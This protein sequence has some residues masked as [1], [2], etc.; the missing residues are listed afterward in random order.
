MNARIAPPAPIDVNPDA[1]TRSARTVVA[2]EATAVE[3]LESRIGPEFVEA[4]RLILG[5]KGRVVV[6]GM[7]SP[8]TSGARS[9]P[10]WPP[11]ARRR[12]SCTRAK[13]ATATSA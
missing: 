6:S 10:P 2:T 3:A 11:P 13:P 7:A 4:C 1:I 5:C 12:S 9:P 8:A